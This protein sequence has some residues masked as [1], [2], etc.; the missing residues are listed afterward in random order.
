MALY[1][2]QK[3]PDDIVITLAIRTALTKGKKGGMKDVPLDGMVF[4][5]LQQV[6]RK[7]NLDPQM[8]ED[9]C[10]GNVRRAVNVA[11]VYTVLI[12]YRCRM[13]K[14]LTT[15]VRPYLQLASRIPLVARL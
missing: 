1:S 2:L 11:M 12:G 9:V 3:N 5:L 15:C 4:K 8:V 13:P 7:M 14:Q 6:V 10:L